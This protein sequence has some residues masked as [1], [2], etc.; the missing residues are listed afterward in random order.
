MRKMFLLF[1]H[2]L[3]ESQRED[4]IKTYNIGEFV[5]LPENFQNMWSQIPAEFSNDEVIKF[6][7]PITKWLKETSSSQ[8]VALVQGDYSATFYLA[9]FCREIEITPVSST[10][11]RVAKEITDGNKVHVSHTFEHIIYREL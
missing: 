7:E 1:S 4:A 11:K 6:I 10:N 8:D 2:K 9:K 5:N 3:T